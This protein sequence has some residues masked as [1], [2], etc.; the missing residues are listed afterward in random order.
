MKL[1]GGRHLTY[2]TN[3]HPGEDLAA[4]RGA[5]RTYTRAVAQRVGGNAPFGVGLRLSAAAAG[6]LAGPGALAELRGLL[7]DLGL[8]VFTVNGFPFGAFH[9]T[10]VKERVYAPDWR[11]VDRVDYTVR[12]AE[13][14]TALL[15]EG[16]DGSIS[17]VPGGFRAA[18]GEADLP[19]ITT[20]L[21]RCAAAL[22]SLRDRTG[23]TVRLALEPEPFCLLETTRDAVLFF[24]RHLWSRPAIASFSRLT[25]LAPA[26]AE[27]T[28]RDLVGVCLDACHLAVAFED[29]RAAVS[30]L[31]AA[32]LGVPKIQVTA[33]L[34]L[35][36]SPDAGRALAPFADDVYLHQVTERRSDG[37]QVH[38]L[39]LPEAIARALP[40]SQLRVHFHVP[41]CAAGTAELGTT[42]PELAT[43]LAAATAA[44]LTTHFEVETYT[45]GVTP[46][47]FTSRDVVDDIAAELQWALSR[48]S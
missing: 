3:I 44:R 2:C 21:L 48:L 25:G 38:H 43:L 30:R 34:D 28:L 12:L 14:L 6:A 13:H 36:W 37:S 7:D 45:W 5:L 11:E 39:D 19:A 26:A 17:T 20:N 16:V 29:P 42:Q 23:K 46:G 8:Y 10:R 41:V 27:S 4:V 9:G 47:S 31:L 22:A 32:G 24:E 18:L 15:P 35:R 33:A 40:G 1:S